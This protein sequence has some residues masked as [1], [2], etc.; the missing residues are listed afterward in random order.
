MIRLLKLLLYS[1]LL[2]KSANC[3]MDRLI[4]IA[5]TWQHI[6][7]GKMSQLRGVVSGYNSGCTHKGVLVLKTGM[8]RFH[9][10]FIPWNNDDTLPYVAMSLWVN[11]HTLGWH[12]NIYINILKWA[13]VQIKINTRV[14]I[15]TCSFQVGC[16]FPGS[17]FAPPLGM[18]LWGQS[19]WR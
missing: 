14:E 6:I 17:A 11:T 19:L 10:W 5:K 13:R 18:S 15:N 1:G 9:K 7:S 12:Y 8:T 4:R 16:K 3:C 2:L